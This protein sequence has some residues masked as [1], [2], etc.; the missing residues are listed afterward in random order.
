MGAAFPRDESGAPSGAYDLAAAGFADA[1]VRKSTSHRRAERPGQLAP[2][3]GARLPTCQRASRGYLE[4]VGESIY[5]VSAP[6][7]PVPPDP[8]LRAWARLRAWRVANW[9]TWL[10]WL[11]MGMAVMHGYLGRLGPSVMFLQLGVF[12]LSG[13]MAL[14]FRC[15]HCGE[16]FSEKSQFTRR[17]AHCGIS[18]GTP[19]SAVVAREAQDSESA[20]NV[21][22]LP[23]DSER[24]SPGA[25]HLGV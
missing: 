11:P 8:Y 14:R 19:R 2:R 10:G 6:K 16:L 21:A 23:D 18:T 17:C 3:E 9:I 24:P 20:T 5:R 7:P 25:R 4:C 13:S 12:A 15:P 1:P 22:D